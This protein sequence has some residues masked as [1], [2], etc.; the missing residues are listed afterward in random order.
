MPDPNIDALAERAYASR[1]P[2]FLPD[3]EG[4]VCVSCG[5]PAEYL[6]DGDPYCLDCLLE[7]LLQTGEIKK[8]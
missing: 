2:Q 8:L 4:P 7:A 6:L 1:D 3:D 5:E